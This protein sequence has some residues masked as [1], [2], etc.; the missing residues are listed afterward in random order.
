MG[1]KKQAFAWEK[2]GELSVWWYKTD[3]KRNNEM[4]VSS[5]CSWGVGGT[6]GVA[7]LATPSGLRSGGVVGTSSGSHAYRQLS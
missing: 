1:G 3:V 6:R 4:I 5:L 7:S 2:L